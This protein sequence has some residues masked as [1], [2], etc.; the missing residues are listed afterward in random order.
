MNHHIQ[1]IQTA[2][3]GLG[4]DPGP[5]DG[6]FGDRTDAAASEWLKNHGS[7]KSKAAPAPSPKL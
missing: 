2:L 7:P 5:L 1:A 4:Y 3:I 6:V